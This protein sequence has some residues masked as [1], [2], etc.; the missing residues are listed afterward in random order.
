LYLQHTQEF[1]ESQQEI[2][3][4]SNVSD[5]KC[6]TPQHLTKPQENKA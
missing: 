1:K 6:T 5:I 4:R 3:C 2:Y